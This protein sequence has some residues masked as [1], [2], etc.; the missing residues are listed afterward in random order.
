MWGIKGSVPRLILLGSASSILINA[1]V[2]GI[3]MALYSQGI[4][5]FYSVPL[6]AVSTVSCVVGMITVS[7][8]TYAFYLDERE[9]FPRVCGAEQGLV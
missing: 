1:F 7:S 5:L 2:L 9:S 6:L 8:I 4:Q 3:L